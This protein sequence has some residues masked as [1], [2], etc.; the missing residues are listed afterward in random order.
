[1]ALICLLEVVHSQQS[2]AAPQGRGQYLATRELAKAHYIQPLTIVQL[3]SLRRQAMSIVATRLSRAEPPMR[4]EVVEYMLHADSHVWTIRRSQ[5]KF[6]RVTA[7][8]S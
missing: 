8:L 2:Q 6:F 3:D 7:L 5:A 4:R 1:V